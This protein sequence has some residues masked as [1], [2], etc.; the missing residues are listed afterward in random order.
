MEDLFPSATVEELKERREQYEKT[1][2]GIKR[3]MRDVEDNIIFDYSHKLYDLTRTMDTRWR[4][5][6]ASH[7]EDTLIYGSSALMMN[8]NDSDP[9]TW[10]VDERIDMN[11]TVQLTMSKGNQRYVKLISTG[12]WYG[13]T[14]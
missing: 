10:R 11:D 6:V 4:N 2:E 7:I 1:P 12:E 13:Q 5:T 9:I 8:T 14:Y 3:A